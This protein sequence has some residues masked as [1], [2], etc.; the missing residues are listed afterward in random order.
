[1]PCGTNSVKKYSQLVQPEVHEYLRDIKFT[2][3]NS[4]KNRT[5]F[6]C[7]R[8]GFCWTCHWIKKEME[9]ISPEIIP[10]EVYG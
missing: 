6:T 2:Y 9:R 1:M 5:Q 10:I 4:C 8:C 7:F 3:C